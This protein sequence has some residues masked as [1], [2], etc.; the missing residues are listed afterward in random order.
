MTFRSENDIVV[1]ILELSKEGSTKVKKMNDLVISHV[2]LRKT[3]AELVDKRLL[4]YIEPKQLYITTDKGIK[5]L[6]M[7]Y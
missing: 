6:N 7:R 1:K 4:K 3:L 2:Q 5:F